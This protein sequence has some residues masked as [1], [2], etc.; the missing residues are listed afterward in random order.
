[1][2]GHRVAARDPV[3]SAPEE[4]RP[5]RSPVHEEEQRHERD[6]A[7]PRVIERRE[8]P[9]G[10]KRAPGHRR[11]ECEDRGHATP[12][13]AGVPGAASFVAVRANRSDR[14]INPANVVALVGTHVAALGALWSFTLEGL[15]CFLVM[16]T[17]TL[18][19]GLIVC[20]HRL[21]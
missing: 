9:T 10:G 7:D 14:P 21:L 18:N 2:H 1:T 17:L 3:A 6:P 13:A 8:C 11:H 12:I 20:F 15:V 4:R 5:C 16:V 19:L